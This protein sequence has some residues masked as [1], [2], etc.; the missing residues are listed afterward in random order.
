MTVI[1]EDASLEA[2][3]DARIR[4]KCDIL[5]TKQVNGMDS[6]A[7][8]QDNQHAECRIYVYYKWY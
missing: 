8:M 6:V 1:Y 3:A 2:I 4:N 7:F 5:P